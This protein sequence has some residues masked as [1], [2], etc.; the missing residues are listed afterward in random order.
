MLFAGSP[1]S[2]GLSRYFLRLVLCLG[3]LAL[4]LTPVWSQSSTAG[5]VA[6]QVVDESNAAVPGTDV[7]LTAIST[8]TSQTTISNNDGRY[9]F[10]SVP[11][12]TYNVMFTKQGFSTYEVNGQTVEVGQVLTLNAK[13]KIGSTS[14]TVEVTASTGAELQT[15]NATV[16]NTLNGMTLRTL[17]NLGSDVTSMSVLQPGVTLTGQMA[18]S[19]ADANTYQLDGANVTDDMGGNVVTYQTNYSGLGGSQ[20]GSIPSG[21]I[22]TPTESIEEIK[23]SVGNQ[24][25]DFA[26]SSGGQIQMV[27]K[28]GSNQIHGSGYM[29]YYDNAIGQANSWANNHTPFSYGSQTFAYTPVDFP[30]NH[31]S[32]FGGALGGPITNKAFLGGK[33]YFFVNYEGHRF[34]D[35]QLFSANVPS[36]LLRAG[37]IQVPDASGK[38]QPYNLNPNPVTVGGTTYAPA[39]CPAGP[40]DPRGIGLNP[41]VNQIWSKQMPLANNPLG[42]DNYNTQGFLGSIRAPLTSDNYVARID[43]DFSD[44]W[45]YYVT[46]RD[47]KLVNLTTNQVDIGGALPGDTL[48]TP[49]AKAPRPQ[50]PSVWTTGMTTTITPSTTN[51]FVFSY[52]HQYWAWGS[53]NGPAQLPGLGGALEIGGEATTDLIPYNVNTQSVRQRF[54]DGQDK[55]I[56]D[57]LT[58]LKGNHLFSFGGTYQRNFDYHSRTDNGA[59]TNDQVSYL[60]TSGGFNWTSPTPQYIPTAVPS[61]QY[62]TWE[63]NYAY[64]LGMLSST[65]V[66]YTRG[67]PGLNLEAIGTPATDKSIIPSYNVN[68]ADV[69][70]MKPSFT[71]TYGLGYNLEM[72]PYEL[73][74]SQVSLVDASGQPVVSTDFIAQRQAAAL[75]GQVYAPTLGF[76]LVRGVGSGLKYPYNPYYGEFAPRVSF[77]WNPHYNDGILGKIVGNG[78]TVLRGGYG[79]IWGRLNGVDL[80]LVPLLGPGLLQGVTCTNPLMN[81]TCAGTGVAT[82]ANA[83]R[84]GSDGMTAPL[85]AATPTLSQPFYPGI[86]SNPETVDPSALDP[87]FRPDRTDQFTITLQRELNPHLQLEVGYIGKLIRNTFMEVNLDSVPYMTTLGGQSFA[88]AYSQLYQQLIF[89]GVNPLNV[90]AQP[91]FE[92][93]LG[94]SKSAFCSGFASCTVAVAQN[95]STLI[96]E[97]AVSDLWN[98]LGAANGWTLGHTVYS[99]P[100]PGSTVG[101]ATVLGMIGSFGWANYNSLFSSVRMNDWHGLTAISNFTWGR[102][103]GTGQQV[104]STSSATP[105]SAFDIGANYGPQGYDIKFIYN[106]SMYYA[107]PFFKG[108]HGVLGH[109]LGGWVV[110]PLF[111]AQSGSLTSVSYSEGSCTACQAFGEITSAGNTNFSSTS[112]RAVGYMPY[113]GLNGAEYGSVPGATGSNIAFGTAGVGTRTTTPYLQAFTS[114]A[115]VY[116]EFRPCVLGYDTSCGGVGNLRA[117]PT[118]NLDTT[119]SKDIGIY[120]ERLGALVYFTF[121]NIMNHFNP[122]GPS[123][124]LTSATSFGQITGQSNSPRS[125]QFGLRI[126]F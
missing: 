44:K 96:K 115:S 2:Y 82:P 95:Y 1:V 21:V 20:G 102:A 100:A 4:G 15:M 42:G 14:T 53:A 88:S 120:K 41:I 51:T 35:A 114:P 40:C 83:F 63:S 54:W 87:H 105:L 80:V 122:S 89:N 75:Q 112:E 78:K 76:E 13:L 73:K 71:L 93:A 74:G 50:Q 9:A 70:H 11:P 109:L 65:Q 90:T 111:T 57:S 113:S 84:I 97:T 79:R 119:F 64:V 77:A 92:N 72:P 36:A 19:P 29:Y 32:T 62:S 81:G 48:G 107:D 16:G 10:T 56:V 110:A 38:Y 47:Y 5:T 49:A 101:Q 123:L 18:G 7:K 59:G 94:G 60:S 124:N 6:G 85:A 121:T 116:A 3:I 68:F 31:R 26:S 86:G 99:Q 55:S 103:L 125:L 66:M 37:V 33:W 25:S 34:P 98:K 118:W 61:G 24:T 30:K 46:Y 106:L 117:Y 126:H 12:G 43:H 22:P 27:T 52:L 39:V 91:F 69:W 17:P 45:H 23:V 8:N 67:V 104:Q 108:Q 28:R 58:M